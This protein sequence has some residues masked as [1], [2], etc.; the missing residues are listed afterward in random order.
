MTESVA[1]PIERIG[2]VIPARNERQLLPQCLA[3]LDRAATRVTQPVTVV[4]VLD[5]CTDGTGEVLFDGPRTGLNRVV[6]V[7]VAFGNVGRSRA[8]G[9]DWLLAQYPTDSLWLATSDADSSVPDG[10]FSGQLQRATAGA[11]A[12]VGTVRVADWSGHSDAARRSYLD[13]YRDVE[14]HRHMHGANLS[15]RASSYL[16]AG[17]FSP[18]VADEDVRLVDGLI[19][20]G[21]RIAWAGDL[22]VLTSGRLVGR[23]PA[24][25][26]QHLQLITDDP[27]QVPAQKLPALPIAL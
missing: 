2:V 20:A 18:L 15:M 16:A 19:S 8:A 10:W 13:A 12:V 14:D 9:C 27:A 21:Q 23:A 3:A 25:F 26:A 24:G 17:G 4:V 5:S 1:T 6:G 11:D 7:S 22:A